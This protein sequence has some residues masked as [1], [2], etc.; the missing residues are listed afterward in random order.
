MRVLSVT[1]CGLGPE[2]SSTIAESLLANENT[3]LE[4]LC[5]ARSRVED[6]GAIA[7]SNYFD[8]YDGL[9]YLEIWQNGIRNDGMTP[10]I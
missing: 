1:N 6:Q 10:L 8:S 4:K 3:K 2:A 9:T 7:L 5:I